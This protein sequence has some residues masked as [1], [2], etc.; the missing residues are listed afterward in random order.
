[1]TPD[2]NLPT[3]GSLKKDRLEGYSIT[4][5]QCRNAAY[6]PW[7][8][9]PDDLAFIHIPTRR[10]KCSLCGVKRVHISPDWR[11]YRANGMG[12]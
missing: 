12:G 2:S 3:V 9:L 7:G 8:T 11:Q 1:M 10:F 5:N 4:C 6:F